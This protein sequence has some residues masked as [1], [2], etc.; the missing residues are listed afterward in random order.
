MESM[1]IRERYKVARVL[2]AQRDYALVEAADIQERATPI[3][4]LNLYEGGLLHRYAKICSGIRKEDC[5]AFCGMFLDNDTLAVVFDDCKGVSIDNAF[6]RGD[7]WNWR[8]RTDY[9][10]L[11]LHHALSLSTLPPEI[12]CA[13]MLSENLLFDTEKKTV[14]SRHMIPPMNSMNARELALLS[15]DQILKILPRR[16]SSGK[17]EGAFLDSLERGEYLS[18]VTLYSAW[19]KTRKAIEEER[20]AFDKTNP[21]LRGISMLKRVVLRIRFRRKSGGGANV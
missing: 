18:I 7:S 17:C 1:L 16:F 4:L 3:R 14:V 10:E 9:A 15:G 8:E 13:A 2:W 20:E 6:F 21:I 19:R 5:P 11:V 12:S